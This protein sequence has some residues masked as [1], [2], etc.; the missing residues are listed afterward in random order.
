MP[1]VRAASSSA[2]SGACE[3]LGGCLLRR[4]QHLHRRFGDLALAERPRYRRHRLERA[5]AAHS[6]FRDEL[7]IPWR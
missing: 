6:T 7:D 4:G 5:G 2:G 1:I 3:G